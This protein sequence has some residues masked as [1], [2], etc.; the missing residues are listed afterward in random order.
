MNGTA[1]PWRIFF[2]RIPLGRR[3]KNR[4]PQGW[5]IPQY[6][7]LKSK[8]PKYRLK[9]SSIPQYRKPPCP[10]P[11]S[12]AHLP[13]L[14][15]N[16]KILKAFPKTLPTKVKPT[17]CP[18]REKKMRPEKR[19]KKG[20]EKAKSKSQ[21]CCVTFKPKNYLVILLSA[22]TSQAHILHLD[23]KAAKCTTCKPVCGKF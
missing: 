19:K 14:S 20:G 3:M 13:F 23:Q 7:T 12:I 5:M 22:R 16:P 11:C 21:D 1:I 2:Y 17:K 8:L 10:P 9:E 6:R 15:P 18:A 4:I